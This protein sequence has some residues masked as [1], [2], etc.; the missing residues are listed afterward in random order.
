MKRDFERLSEVLDSLMI[1]EN[2]YMSFSEICNMAGISDVGMDAFIRD[3]FGVSG[4]D[5]LKAFRYR[6]P[7][8][9]L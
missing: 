9:F 3:N 2:P 8:C 6:I 4:D 5:I 7:L 1:Y